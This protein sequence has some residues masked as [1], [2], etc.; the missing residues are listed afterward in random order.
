MPHKTVILR[1]RRD[2]Q[3]HRPD[4]AVNVQAKAGRRLAEATRVTFARTL[5][6]EDAFRRDLDADASQAARPIS[7]SAAKVALKVTEPTADKS[8]WD[9]RFRRLHRPQP[10]RRGRSRNPGRPLRA[11]QAR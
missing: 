7:G 6:A 5:G 3:P 4:R 1:K 8:A 11:K 2:S 9:A 10:P